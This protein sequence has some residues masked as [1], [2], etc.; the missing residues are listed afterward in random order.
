MLLLCV[1][2]EGLRA[3]LEN[4]ESLGMGTS[5]NDERLEEV[6][7]RAEADRAR[8]ESETERLSG[9]LEGARSG[10]REASKQAEDARREL[11][12]AHTLVDDVR[13]EMRNLEAEKV[14]LENRIAQLAQKNE[15]DHSAV[16]NSLRKAIETKTNEIDILRRTNAP[17]AEQVARAQ[18]VFAREIAAK[19]EEIRHLQNRLES[20]RMQSAQR[21]SLAEPSRGGIESS[22]SLSGSSP[23]LSLGGAA[24]P[25]PKSPQASD[26]SRRASMASTSSRRSRHS[27]S[28]T[29]TSGAKDDANQ[30]VGLQYMLKEAQ[31]DLSTMSTRDKVMAQELEE[32]KHQNRTLELTV[33]KLSAGKL[34]VSGEGADG[35]SLDGRVISTEDF[36]KLSQSVA[37]LTAQMERKDRES[38]KAL[39]R[40][41]ARVGEVENKRK[42]EVDALHKE[43]HELEA[44]V[45]AEIFRKDELECQLDVLKRSLDK[46]QRQQQAENRKPPHGREEDEHGRSRSSSHSSFVSAESDAVRRHVGANS[47]SDDE[48]LCSL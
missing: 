27:T 39:E 18:E 20:A 35:K 32:L 38:S 13:Q 19:D 33:E 22:P 40:E 44:L 21:D 7:K 43:V 31:N 45:E 26:P 5:D 36:I 30:V 25:L 41:R 3:D 24:S 29:T 17:P 8:F 9:L 4:M 28:G 12:E 1:Q 37:E 42:L 16:I 46:A 6:S 48:D 10:K 34:N 14:E 47:T 2:V 11:Q 15:A 23:R